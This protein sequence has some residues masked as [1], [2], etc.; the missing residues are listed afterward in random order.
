MVHIYLY[1]YTQQDC[2]IYKYWP[3]INTFYCYIVRV[4][5]TCLAC[6]VLVSTPLEWGWDYL[7]VVA[8]DMISTN[9]IE[10]HEHSHYIYSMSQNS[11]N[12]VYCNY[13]EITGTYSIIIKCNFPHNIPIVSSIF[14]MFVWNFEEACDI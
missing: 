8:H 2:T 9:V 4:S 6:Y 14:K 13:K 1:V 12:I 7:V 5:N 10:S 3:V 11:V